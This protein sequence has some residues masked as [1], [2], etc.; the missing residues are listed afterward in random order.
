VIDLPAGQHS[1]DM[2]DHTDRSQAAV[3]EA[4]TWVTTALT[5]D[6]PFFLESG[7]STVEECARPGRR[8]SL[9]GFAGVVACGEH[10]SGGEAA[11]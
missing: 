9:E 5:L 3:T 2:L 1:F 11:V 10:L 6:P 7:A 4:M 8:L